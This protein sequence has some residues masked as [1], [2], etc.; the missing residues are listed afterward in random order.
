[1]ENNSG[2]LLKDPIV[3]INVGVQD[4]GEALEQQGIKVIYVDWTPPAGGDQ[5]MINI[6]EQLL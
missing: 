6:L 5:K 1:M 4:F 3:A 2:D